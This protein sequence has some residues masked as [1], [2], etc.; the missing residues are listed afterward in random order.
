MSHEPGYEMLMQAFSGIMSITGETD[1]D[2]VRCGPSVCDFGS[3]MWLA[4]GVV[5]ALNRRLQTGEGCIV[6]TSVYEA[7]LNWILVAS[8]DYLGH[9]KEPVRVGNGHPAICPYGLYRTKDGALILGVGNDRLFAKLVKVLNRE[10]L[11]DDPRFR[12]NTARISHREV[13]EE[14]IAGV[15]SQNTTRHWI[16]VLTGA[17]VP[18]SP[19]H[20]VPEALEH[21]QTKALKILETAEDAPELRFIGLPLSFNGVRPGLNEAAPNVGEDTDA[22]LGSIKAKSPGS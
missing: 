8:G 3:G 16:S 7:A 19:L 21:P 14:E 10:N 18:C 11:L 4:L 2:P 6:N 1:G 17:G 13:V 12:T 20:T 15:F 5:A 9:G 22:V